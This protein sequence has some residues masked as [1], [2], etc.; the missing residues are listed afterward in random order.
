M[1][2]T[3]T[4]Q[5]APEVAPEVTVTERVD[6]QAKQTKKAFNAWLAR[7]VQENKEILAREMQTYLH[8]YKQLFN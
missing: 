6:A 2:N 7:P 5:N 1:P 4:P 8:L 3:P